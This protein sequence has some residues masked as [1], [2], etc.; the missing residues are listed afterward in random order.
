VIYKLI[1]LVRDTR[2]WQLI[3]G[4]VFIVLF[5][6]VSEVIGLSTIAYILNNSIQYFV[7]TMVILFQPELRRGLEQ[8]GRSRFRTFFN[9]MIVVPTQKDKDELIYNYAINILKE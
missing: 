9:F 6:K 5:A 3:K 8:I 1:Q 4:L 7:L 2:A